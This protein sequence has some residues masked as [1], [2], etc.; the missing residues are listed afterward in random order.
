MIKSVRHIQLNKI[1]YAPNLFKAV[2]ISE[3]Y[4]NK[5]DESDEIEHNK[6]KQ[7]KLLNNLIIINGENS[8]TS[9]TTYKRIK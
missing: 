5:Y 6:T 7:T 1:S 2:I 4:N 9:Q 3:P 8:S